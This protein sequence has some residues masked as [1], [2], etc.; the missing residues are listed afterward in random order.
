MKKLSILLIVSAL[1]IL[2]AFPAAASFTAEMPRYTNIT[3][4]AFFEVLDSAVGACTV[5]IPIE[6]KDNYLAF[7][8]SGDDI[9]FVIVNVSNSTINGVVI[10]PDGRQYTC[11]ATRF[12]W[13][14]YQ[15]TSSPY[16]Q[17]LDLNPEVTTMSNS[18]IFFLTEN[19]LYYNNTVLDYNKIQLAFSCLIFM[20]LILDLFVNLLR[21]GRRAY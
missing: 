5:I 3:G 6:F 8:L 16:N 7:V 14:E 20:V 10:T 17:W 18:N 9:P 12:S 21:K 13:F 4:G 2:M 11:R 1:I 19:P 15:D